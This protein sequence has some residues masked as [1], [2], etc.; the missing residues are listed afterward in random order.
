MNENFYSE[1]YREYDKSNK[2][3]YHQYIYTVEIIEI[4]SRDPNITIDEDL[5]LVGNISVTRKSWVSRKYIYKLFSKLG[6]KRLDGHDDP[7]VY[8][9]NGVTIHVW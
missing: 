3:R 6:A 1:L 9:Y 8:D 4:L 2:K 7:L 5:P